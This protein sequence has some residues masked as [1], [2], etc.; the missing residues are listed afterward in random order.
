M[1]LITAVVPLVA[2]PCRL[3]CWRSRQDRSG[4]RP[5]LSANAHAPHPRRLQQLAGGPCCPLGRPATADPA[6]A[7]AA[8]AADPPTRAAALNGP[9]SNRWIEPHSTPLSC[10]RSDGTDPSG[11]PTSGGPQT[12]EDRT[13]PSPRNRSI[14]CKPSAN[15]GANLDAIR[16]SVG[17]RRWESRSSS[18]TNRPR[19]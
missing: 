19:P 4:W 16:P 11:G 6:A 3:L 1:R 10:W 7:Q 18:V 12:G 14:C 13:K 15:G 5:A 17:E 9:C 8:G 2:R